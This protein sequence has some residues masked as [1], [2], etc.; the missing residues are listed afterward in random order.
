MGD[1]P[2]DR[3]P[4]AL[5]PDVTVRTRGIMEKCTYC[6]Q[7][8]R[9]AKHFASEQKRKVVD[10]EIRT[11]CEVSCA[12]NAIVFGNLKDTNSQVARLRRNYRSYLM[13]GGDHDHKHYGIKTLPNTSYMAKVVSGKASHGKGHHD[14]DQ[15]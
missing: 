5:N 7:R 4:R 1:R 2:I 10:R 12:S 9:D 14:G 13:L 8:I 15:G 3:N 11:A 6:V